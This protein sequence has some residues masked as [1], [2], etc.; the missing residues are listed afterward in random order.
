MVHLDKVKILTAQRWTHFYS[1]SE[2]T[3]QTCLFIE[4]LPKTQIQQ[5]KRKK[6][7]H[8][9]GMGTSYLYETGQMCFTKQVFIILFTDFS[10]SRNKVLKQTNLEFLLIMNSFKMLYWCYCRTFNFT[11]LKYRSNPQ[12]FLIRIKFAIYLPRKE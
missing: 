1:S 11:H 2:K 3:P 10:Y 6:K 7:T 5:C 12:L 4:P 9:K 8:K